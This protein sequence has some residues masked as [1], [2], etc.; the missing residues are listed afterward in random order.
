MRMKYFVLEPKAKQPNDISAK[1]SC[2]A[3]RAYAEVIKSSDPELASV[4]MRWVEQ[5]ELE[6]Q[7]LNWT[8]EKGGH[9]VQ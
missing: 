9:V 2:A 8:G 4:I 5:E 1:A 3:L 6:A 7:K